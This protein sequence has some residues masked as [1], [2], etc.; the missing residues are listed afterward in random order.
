MGLT[1]FFMSLLCLAAF[2]NAASVPMRQSGFTPFA[3]GLPTGWKTWAARPEIAPR[4]FVDLAHYRRA[5]GSLAISGNS[6]AAEYG[7]WEYTASHV[8]AGKWYRFVA[9]YRAEGISDERHQ[10]VARI[11]WS[12]RDGERAGRPDYAYATERSGDW[13]RL[14][15]NVPAPDG[16]TNATVQLYLQNA[17]YATLW[18]DEVS[19]EQIP[20][21]AARQVRVAAVNLHPHDTDSA[22]ESV[23]QFIQAI[24]KS[25]PAGTDV[26]LLPEGITLVGTGKQYAEVA[27]SLPGPTTERLAKVARSKNAYIVAGLFER[28]GPAI[29]NTAVLL[30]RTGSLVGKYRKVYLPREEIEGGLTPG[31]DYPVF[32]TDFGRVGI[33]ICWDVQYADPARALALQG[34]EMILMPIWGGNE[35]LGKARAIEN[36]IFLISSGYDYPTSIVDPD[37]ELLSI[38]RD[39]GTVAQATI[40]LNRRYLD[41]WL[42]DMRERFMKE[43]RLD[44]PLLS[45][46]Y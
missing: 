44:V 45:K 27:E 12:K 18:W 28:E 1:Q 30:D 41:D 15:L 16:A 42:G 4:T 35:T 7:G 8:E 26:I 32:R 34:A 43:V 17:P 38:A 31:N 23:S 3:D 14:W 36:K 22:E 46:P 11:T 20:A 39:P 40:D 37:G 33:M 9:Y 19:L 5:P 2:A 25:V 21:P 24:D 10:I 6:N 29:Y 13:T